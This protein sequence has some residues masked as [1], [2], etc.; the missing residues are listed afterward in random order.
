MNPEIMCCETCG[1]TSREKILFEKPKRIAFL[2]DITVLEQN[3]G[4]KREQENI[5]IDCFKKEIALA[6]KQHKNRFTIYQNDK[7][8]GYSK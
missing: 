2:S 7:L 4:D 5:C 8:I 3:T 6:A 1:A